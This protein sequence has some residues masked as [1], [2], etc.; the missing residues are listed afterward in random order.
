MSIVWKV[1]PKNK[2]HNAFSN[3][4]SNSVR[5]SVA[6]RYNT[7][8]K[9][10]KKPVMI[11][12]IVVFENKFLKKRFKFFTEKIIIPIVEIITPVVAKKLKVS[13]NNISSKATI[14]ITSVLLN[15]VPI[16]KFENWNR[17]SIIN[18]K[19]ICDIDADIK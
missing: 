4:E 8:L 10:K 17:Y 11:P 3:F 13:P 1:T 16:I 18:V 6:P 15:D 2:V 5:L 12:I 7:T 9:P 19:I 14:C